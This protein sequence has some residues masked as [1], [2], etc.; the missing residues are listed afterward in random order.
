MPTVA[1]TPYER[2]VRNIEDTFDILGLNDSEK[3]LL[4]EPKHIHKKSVTITR[5]DGTTATFPAFR[6]QHS[7][8]RGPYKG[9]IRYHELADEDE[10]KALAA[11]MSI[12]TAVVG[13]PFGGGK[14]GVQCSPK[15]LSKKELQAVSR[16]YVQAFKDH[17]GPDIDCPAPDVNTTPQIMA[18]MRDEFENL[19]GG[20]APAMITGKPLSYG[21]S[22]GR[23]TATAKGGFYIL[24]EL[25]EGEA[26]DKKSLRVAVQGFGNAGATMAR[27]LH[28]V[29][30]TVVAVSDSQGGIYNEEG[31]DPVRIAKYKEKTG[32]VTGEYCTGSVCDIE[33]MKMDG[34]R[35]VSNEELLTLPCDILVPAALDNVITDANAAAIQARFI[36]ELANGR[37]TP[38]ADLLLEKRGV[39]VVPDVLANAGGVT[40]SYFEW[41]QGRSGEQWTD[42]YVDSELRRI[43]LG[44][45][46][47]VRREVHRRKISY[48]KAAFVVG[49]SRIVDAMRVRGWVEM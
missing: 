11:L 35:R 30:Y 9:G 21:G 25:V 8:A 26:L 37:T 34:V 28:E 4:R 42:Q 47:D 44:A 24:E 15:T 29:G 31:L 14:G 13:I 19:T 27:L 17:L 1:R 2:F 32:S 36:L 3:H 7:N 18:W 23:D 46:R 48:R 5:D 43:I 39:R 38:E 49:V 20:Y 6:V 41:T 45:Y 12:K 33:K 10:V 40:V 16:A 22:R